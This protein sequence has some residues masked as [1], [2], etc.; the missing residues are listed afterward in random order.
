MGKE[1]EGERIPAV[2][3]LIAIPAGQEFEY[4]SKHRGRKKGMTHKRNERNVVDC[5]VA[6]NRVQAAKTVGW[7]GE[8]TGGWGPLVAGGFL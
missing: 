8:Q 5:S 4:L 1:R 6:D 3:F 2:P 7:G